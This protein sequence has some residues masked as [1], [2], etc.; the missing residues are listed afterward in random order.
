MS[1]S[2]DESQE[3]YTTA[4]CCDNRFLIDMPDLKDGEKQ[5]A[6]TILKYMKRKLAG[7]PEKENHAIEEAQ[8]LKNLFINHVLLVIPTDVNF[9]KMHEPLE[10]LSRHLGV[11]ITKMM[12][13]VFTCAEDLTHEQ[14]QS[15]RMRMFES[16]F[17]QVF[18]KSSLLCRGIQRN[19]N[20]ITSLASLLIVWLHFPIA[21]GS[22]PVRHVL[23]Q[24]KH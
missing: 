4:V 21:G 12:T 14:E 13:I 11:A 15:N 24:H 18:P 19:L 20:K 3:I 17:Q 16:E 23:P 6:V 9:T 8:E 22:T 1:G 5:T 7:S 2:D 10:I